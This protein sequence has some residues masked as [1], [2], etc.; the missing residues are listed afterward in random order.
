MKTWRV[1][2]GY[3]INQI[4]KGENIKHLFGK[5]WYWIDGKTLIKTD[6]LLKEMHPKMLE[7]YNRSKE[8]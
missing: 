8:K 7:K 2:T 1:P 6:K 4:E 3:I 5:F